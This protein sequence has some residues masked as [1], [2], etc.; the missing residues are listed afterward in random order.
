MP[1]NPPVRRD[2]V[3]APVAPVAVRT[4]LALHERWE[5]VRLLPGGILLQESHVR[6][7]VARWRRM[8]ESR[9]P[10]WAVRVSGG[11]VV[12]WRNSV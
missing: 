6:T 3:V 5:S 10:A 2:A 1:H 8:P 12:A 11:F 9:D 7:T 4:K